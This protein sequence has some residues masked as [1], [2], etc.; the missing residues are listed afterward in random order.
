[1]AERVV[2]TGMGAVTP[3]GLDLET[4]WQNLL[5]G[6]SGAGPI[7]L[8]D[9][10]E[11]RCKIAAEVKNFD[12][13]QHLPPKDARRNDRSVQFAVAAAR[14]AVQDADLAIDDS[15]RDHIGVVIGSGVGGIGSLSEQYDVMRDRGVDRVSPFLVPMFIIDMAPGV[16]SMV[17]GARG[18]NYSIVSAC[19]SAGHCIGESMEIL[20]RGDAKVMITGGAEAG[21]VP[22]GIGSFDAMRALSTRNDDPVHASRPFDKDRDGFVMGEGAGIMVLETL[23]HARER[24]ARIHGELV[25]YGATG[26]AYHITA[27][28]ES[29]EGAVR[30]MQMGLRKA[31]LGP[32]EVDYINAHATSTPNG[33]RAETTAIKSV[34]GRRAY[35]I[36]ISS[37]KSMT[38]HLMG[39]GAAVEGMF[40]LLAMRHGIVPPTTNLEETDPACDLDYVPNVAR[41]RRVE[42]AVS[43]SFGFGGHNNT[44]VFRAFDGA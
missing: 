15:N 18:P 6:Q 33:D 5:E 4:T 3:L 30:S 16:V 26:D 11:M 42:V 27:P 31:G 24:G 38:G 19:S 43:N 25:G 35:D 17:L 13:E 7:T 8:F 1:M 21:I 37:T 36:P 14:Q 44:L 34:F 28:S 41:R 10:A 22:I 32:D 20:K 39:A 23:R 12:P 29:G 9:P 40:C 2:I